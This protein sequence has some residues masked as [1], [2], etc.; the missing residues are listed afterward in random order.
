VTCPISPAQLDV[1]K[2]LLI[3]QATSTSNDANSANVRCVLSSTSAVTCN[4]AGNNDDVEVSWQTAE[5]ASG[6]KVQQQDVLCTGQS[7]LTVPLQAVA[8]PGNTFLLV[9]SQVDGTTQGA[10]DF[11]TATLAA[12]DRV[13]LQFGTPCTSTWRGAVQVVELTG[14]SVT[15]GVTEAMAGTQRT[16]TGLP[17]V[18][19]ATT[20][21]LFTYRVA[22][23]T[24]P[25]ICDRVLRGE[26]TSPTSLTFTRAAGATGC[27]D[28]IIE[29][30]SW[31]R[32]ELGTRGQAQHLDVALENGVSG[33]QLTISPVD[34]TRTLVFSSSQA[35]SGQG[36]GEGSYAGDDILG[37]V[38]GH[39]LL[40]SPTVLEV[41]RDISAGKARWFSTVLQLEP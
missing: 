39:H 30:I 14:A 28:A 2:T 40:V 23:A 17:A 22:S 15:R 8:N 4:R 31:E 6:L 32:I 24:Q 29:S 37:T 41:H 36:G 5:L 11:F 33:T 1:S 18:D 12:A 19:P 25:G 20:V 34:P 7:T 21:L 35:L 38:M 26:L 16:V 10:D 9:G 13:D 3:Y 27:E